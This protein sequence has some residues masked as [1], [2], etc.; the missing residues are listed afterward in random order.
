MRGR[1]NHTS[2]DWNIFSDRE[3]QEDMFADNYLPLYWDE[4]VTWPYEAAVSFDTYPSSD[5]AESSNIRPGAVYA[6]QPETIST[7]V[8]VP[9]QVEPNTNIQNLST[10]L[11]LQCL[12]RRLNPVESKVLTNSG[13]SFFSNRQ[14]SL[15]VT[16]PVETRIILNNNLDDKLEEN[17]WTNLDCSLFN[18]DETMKA[19]EFKI[20]SNLNK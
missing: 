10:S 19:L 4:S 15:A 18:S 13:Y 2:S 3:Y 6:A 12:S 5:T 9:Q 8:D 20:Y 7:A 11:H 17:R 16:S 1:T 14:L